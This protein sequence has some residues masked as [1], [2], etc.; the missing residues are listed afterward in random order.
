MLEQWALT[1]SLTGLDNRRNVL[2]KAE[3]EFIRSNRFQY[4]LTAIIIDID[5]FKQVNDTYGHNI[6]DQVLKTVGKRCRNQLRSIDMIGRYGGDEFLVFLIETNYDEARDVAHR[7]RNCIA[8]EPIV[9]DQGPLNVTI[10]L[11]IATKDRDS[12]HET[13]IIDWAD[14]ALLDAKK[15]G[16]NNIG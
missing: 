4:D 8:E 13:D 1:D 15:S 9:T 6:G 5:D 14:Q 11:G 2:H 7:L 12:N 3:M 10:S 16:K